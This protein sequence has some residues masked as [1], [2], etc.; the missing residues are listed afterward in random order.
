MKGDKS[1]PQAQTIVF[2][3]LGGIIA[4]VIALVQ[5]K[6]NLVFPP[7]LLGNFLV[8]V[9]LVTPAYLLSYRAYQLIG[10][11][12]V[13]MFLATG[14]LWNVIGAYVLLHEAV[15]VKMMIGAL[16]IVIGVMISRYEKK[17]FTINKGIVLVLVAAL[18]FGMSDIDG[19]YILRS[20]NATNYLIYS[21]LLPVFAI[22]VFRPKIIKK[23]SYYFQKDKAIKLLLLSACDAIG[24]LTLFLAYQAGHNASIIGP[25]SAMRII[26]TVILAMIFLKERSNIPNK[27][28]GAVVTVVGVI[29]LL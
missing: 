4:I 27:L 23:L 26:V 28:V 16:I 15:S 20:V 10:A 3:G 14:R 22:L 6:F 9:L 8:F 5:E 29:L 13:A 1:N 19:Y 21:E 12:E 18:L 2:L 7:A 24:M 17:R 11:T 25:L